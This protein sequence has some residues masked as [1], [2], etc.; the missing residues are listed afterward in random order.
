MR[1]IILFIVLFTI[2]GVAQISYGLATEQ[3][4]PDSANRHPTVAQLDWP[5]GIVEI[6]RHESRV[7]SIWVNGNE[8]FYFKTTAEQINELI[9]LFSK[10]RMRD[11]V[12]RIRSGM[13][14]TRTFG[15]EE[16]EYNVSLQIVT[17]IVLFVAREEKRED[18][19]LEPELTILTGDERAILN[20]LRWPG[21]VI[22]QSELP[23]VSIKSNRVKPKRDFYYGRLEF[24]D[25][26]PPVEFVRGIKSWITLWE[27]DAEDGINVGSVNNKGYFTVLLSGEELANFKKGKLWLTVT[28]ANFLTDARKTDQRFPIEMLT[29]DKDKAQPVKV[30]GPKYYYG[31]ILFEDGSAPI[32]NPPPWPG[33]EIQ[34]DFP[35]AGGAAIDSQ[36]YFKVHFSEEQYEKVK[37]EKV[38]KNIYIPDYSEK[39]QSTA[40]FAFP[41]ALLSQDKTKAGVVKIPRPK[42]P[43]QELAT[44]ES[45][46]GKSIPGFDNIRFDVF[47]EDQAKN[48]PL[49]V[50]FW[51]IDQRPSR[52]CIL[53]LKKQKDVLQDKNIVILA[54][55]SGTK[56]EKE[57]R[58]WL[59]E[60]GLSLMLGTIEGDPY[61]TLLAWGVKGLPWLILTD[62]QHIITNA[63]FS[64]ADLS[65]IH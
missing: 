65:V 46:I 49:L 19:P 36:G 20:Q 64:L 11:H 10:A 53:M 37:A 25:G 57:V 52:Q 35:Y 41:V 48:K 43:K 1:K 63:G 34:V 2:S 44:A 23:G 7:Y 6:P 27:Q 15:G 61:D 14:K 16:I 8:N 31:R 62:E 38:R 45:K 24:E 32:L 30:R 51:D 33:A 58:E 28:I 55:H 26:S 56:P 4:G 21:N 47:R 5:K 9:S 40:R 12:A 17:G 54:I 13:G 59:K 42:L 29:R 50:C 39:G 60:N 22:V 18:L 3:V